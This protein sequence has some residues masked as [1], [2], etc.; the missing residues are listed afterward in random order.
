MIAIHKLTRERFQV[1]R[2]KMS[3]TKDRLGITY[4]ADEMQIY[5]PK[6]RKIIKVD[7]NDYRIVDNSSI[8]ILDKKTGKFS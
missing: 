8:Q 5:Y 6:T 2:Y 7:R 3:F 1:V 4:G